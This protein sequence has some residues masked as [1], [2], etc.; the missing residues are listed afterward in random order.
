[1][2]SCQAACLAV[3][4]A[5]LAVPATASERT[6]IE[7]RI[8]ALNP[9]A[10]LETE[11]FGQTIGLTEV[12]D[13]TLRAADLFLRGDEVEARID[14]R[15]ACRTPEGGFL[16]GDASA[17]VLAEAT[18]TLE[19]CELNSLD[20]TLSDFDGTFGPVLSAF[21]SEIENALAEEA[22]SAFVAGC[23]SFVGR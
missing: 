14:G 17:D 2:R 6:I 12:E 1:M 4:S 15:I 20:I 16:T 22:R 5:A 3:L 10:G 7:R 23:R 9:C 18:V 21:A 11:Q 19:T 13:V 8:A